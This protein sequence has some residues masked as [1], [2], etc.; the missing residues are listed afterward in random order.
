[1]NENKESFFEYIA[2]REEIARLCRID[3][4]AIVLYTGVDEYDIMIYRC[5][6]HKKILQWSI[7]LS[8][9]SWMTMPLLRAFVIT[10]ADYHKLNLSV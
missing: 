7:H 3:G 9:K 6:T 1:M 5:D 10:A 4:D 8:A 2:D